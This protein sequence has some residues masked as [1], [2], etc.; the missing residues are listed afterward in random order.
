MSNDK[1]SDQPTSAGLRLGLDWDGTISC[2][3]PELRRL[4]ACS[5]AIVIITLNDEITK[6]IAANV[7]GATEDRIE[8]CICPD[9]RVEDYFRWKAESC[10]ARSIQLMIDDDLHVAQACWAAGVPTLLVA[11]RDSEMTE[12]V[13]RVAF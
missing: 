5:G 13:G 2:Y 1:F 4:V 12:R 10:L 9:D 6:T 8:V 3:W 7:L 11:E